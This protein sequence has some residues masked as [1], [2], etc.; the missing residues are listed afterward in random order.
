MEILLKK[1]VARIKDEILASRNK[2][3]A[4]IKETKELS[5]GE[6]VKDESKRT[7]DERPKEEVEERLNRY[8]RY[9]FNGKEVITRRHI[10]L[11]R[12]ANG[13]LPNYEASRSLD[14]KYIQFVQDV[15][16]FINKKPSE[17]TSAEIDE[18]NSRRKEQMKRRYFIGGEFKRY[19]DGYVS[20]KMVNES[21]DISLEVSLSATGI[22]DN[23]DE[24]DAIR[25]LGTFDIQFDGETL[26]DSELKS[27][28]KE[29]LAEKQMPAKLIEKALPAAVDVTKILYE[30]NK[31]YV[32]PKIT[33]EPVRKESSTELEGKD[34]SDTEPQPKIVHEKIDK[35]AYLELQRK[36]QRGENLSDDERQKI[37][38][39]AENLE[40]NE[41][42]RETLYKKFPNVKY[43]VDKIFNLATANTSAKRHLAKFLASDKSKAGDKIYPFAALALKNLCYVE[44]MHRELTSTLKRSFQKVNDFIEQYKNNEISAKELYDKTLKKLYNQSEE[45]HTKPKSTSV[46]EEKLE[47]FKLYGQKH[48]TV[49]KSYH[50]S[51]QTYTAKMSAD[52]ENII[53][54]YKENGKERYSYSVP[55]S[56]FEKDGSSALNKY[57]TQAIKERYSKSHSEK[58]LEEAVEIILKAS[59][60]WHNSVVGKMRNIFR[61][62]VPAEENVSIKNK[63]ESEENVIDDSADS[64]VERIGERDNQNAVGRNDESGESKQG[65]VSEG[66]PAAGERVRTPS[67]IRVQTGGTVDSGEIGDS[68]IQTEE[69]ENS[70]DSAGS[71]EL[72]GSVRDN[73][74]RSDID[75][76]RKA[77]S[78]GT[79]QNGR[80]NEGTQKV[81]SKNESQRLQE[82]R[83]E[84]PML[85]PAQQEDVEFIEKRL[86]E[87]GGTGVLLTNGTGTGK[88]FSGL[89]AVKRMFDSGKK[90]ILIV[91]P[92]E[93]VIRQWQDAAKNYFGLDVNALENTKDKGKENQ[94]CITTYDN[95][96]QNKEL[97]KRNWDAVI[98]DESHNLMQNAKGED[99]GALETLREITLH[100]RRWYELWQARNST[101]KIKKLEEELAELVEQLNS[102]KENAPRT[103]RKSTDVT[104]TEFN[105]EMKD[106]VVGG[107][108]WATNQKK[109]IEYFQ[110]KIREKQKEISDAYFEL[111]DKWKKFKSELEKINPAD[112]PKVVF[113][114]ATP[115]TEK[116]P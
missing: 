108:T 99:T 14:K 91:A 60:Y 15:S 73:F 43:L 103:L 115:F 2:Q 34:L 84:L 23:W 36:A 45:S 17:M 37:L 44:N 114:S 102:V 27:L 96:Q 83:K 26:N 110:S 10:Y 32:S 4:K 6:S 61:S 88:T 31:E 25:Q 46:Y 75:D 66:L 112:R 38:D 72:A 41:E 105:E 89:G 8:T 76:G 62:Y 111:N 87:K 94:I 12:I 65:S 77:E 70:A 53:V 33:L 97:V 74:T 106:E 78:I 7:E 104:T 40:V 109:T 90:N 28:I 93:D 113:L 24:F 9:D 101:A 59:G 39:N 35:T 18:F 107:E 85:L 71:N 50:D 29:K 116:A 98:A 86:F 92:S 79:A 51:K 47:R 3:L 69:S 80:I 95:L 82:I 11:E 5:N 16:K 58:Q 54:T 49:S 42:L 100:P 22:A 67:G 55:L 63:G 52:C 68:G 30:K 48:V 56:E 64:V 81:N 57:L 21:N 13:E 19:S 1:N 20:A